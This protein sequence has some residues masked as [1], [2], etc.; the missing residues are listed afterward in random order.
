MHVIG[1][2]KIVK[3]KED[4]GLGIQAAK[5]KNTALLAK[6]NWRILLDP[7]YQ[8]ITHLV[9]IEYFFIKK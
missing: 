5:T 9:Q 8:L 4:R 3:P 6:L 7:N 1:W 2:R